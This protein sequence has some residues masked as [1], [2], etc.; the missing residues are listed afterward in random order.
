MLDLP[1]TAETDANLLIQPQILINPVT[2]LLHS[3]LRL[4]LYQMMMIMMMMMMKMMI[5]IILMMMDDGSDDDE[6]SNNTNKQYL[7]VTR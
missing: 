6:N 3:H 2:Q 1:K 5:M 7:K 4:H